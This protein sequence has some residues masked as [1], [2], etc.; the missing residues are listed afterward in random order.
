MGGFQKS[1]ESAT[2]QGRG[3]EAHTATLMAQA[4]LSRATGLARLGKYDSAELVLSSLPRTLPEVL[5]LFA[6]IRAQQGR[7]FAA[8]ELWTEA[9]RLDPSN[10]GYRS[11]LRKA[12]QGPWQRRIRPLLVAT[13][14]LLTVT[15][16][17]IAVRRL[18][19]QKSQ[20]TSKHLT[21]QPPTSTP[22][23]KP[24]EFSAPG[25]LQTGSGPTTTLRFEFGLFSHGVRLT[26]GGRAALEAIGRQI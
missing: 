20:V 1:G 17:G 18:V 5:D 23:Q 24:T 16:G 2:P 13:V 14:A 3:F 8:A 11:S 10:A 7:M 12:E 22:A 15:A 4:L 6:K 19:Y 26:S 21:E 25:V 9:L